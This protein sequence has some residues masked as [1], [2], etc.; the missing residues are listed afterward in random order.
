MEEHP[1]SMELTYL[2]N[3]GFLLSDGRTALIFDD[4]GRCPDIINRA[5]LERFDAAVFFVSHS[6]GDHFSPGIFSFSDVPGVHYVLS[7]DVP[8]AG[9]PEGARAARMRPMQQ[10]A[11]ANCS[12]TAFGSTDLGVSFLVLWNGV[13]MF[14]AG[15]LNNW[16]WR[17]E[18][19][20]DEVREAQQAFDA[21]VSQIP[22]SID[23]AFFPVDPRMGSGYDL[24]ARQFAARIRP[25]LFVP[26]HFREAAYA[27]TDFQSSLAV[28]GVRVLPLTESGQRCELPF[29]AAPRPTSL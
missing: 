3:S 11:A 1:L 6:H 4:E 18:S 8:T 21:I 5:A 17:A 7:D 24:G 9:L 29:G 13:H 15:D 12:V 22:R 23:L 25:R 27:A 2:S 28:P 20:D 10:T 19:T 14:H 16:H 26:M